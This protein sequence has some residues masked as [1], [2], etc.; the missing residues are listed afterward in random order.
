[1]MLPPHC[2]HLM[3]PLDIGIFFPLKQAIGTFVN[4]ILRTGIPRLQ[5][6]EWFK[7]FISARDKTLTK[8][9]IRGAWR[10]AGIYPIN[11][12]KVLDKIPPPIARPSDQLNPQANGIAIP[13]TNSA[14]QFNILSDNDAPID[15]TALHSANS[16]LNDLVHA[17]QQLH[18]PARKFIPQ[19]ASTT[20]WL[21]A[22]NVILK[23]ELQKCKDTLGSRKAG[24]RGKRLVLK[25][26]IIA[27]TKEILKAVEECEKATQNR[28]PK[29]GR[30]RGRP[31]KNALVAPVVTLEEAT[32]DED[33]SESGGDN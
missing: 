4:R 12:S 1:M 17:K 21:L 28:K 8:G 25:G 7:C 31:R 29:T 5:K 30:P 27:S 3:Q 13:T 23:L 19:L 26:K 33:A 10:G 11:P 9:N 22:E 16:A 20:E 32:D 14:E 18:T 6:I 15:A 24:G 2:S